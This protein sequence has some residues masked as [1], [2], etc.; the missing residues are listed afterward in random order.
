[1]H[2]EDFSSRND[3][4][5]VD[6]KKRGASGTTVFLSDG[7]SFLLHGS[8]ADAVSLSAQIDELLFSF[9]QSRSEAYAAYAKGFSL[10]A[11][12]EHSVTQLKQKLY[13]RGFSQAAVED[14]AIRLEQARALDD[15]RYA[16]VW[17]RS[18]IRRKRASRAV[19]AAKLAEAG[20]SQRIVA[21]A[22]EE[23]YSSEIELA[24][25]AN[26]FEKLNRKPRMTREKFMA[27]LTRRG[28]SYKSIKKILDEHNIA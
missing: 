27:A 3:N 26:A 17:L 23:L 24:S 28:F 19:L 10:C 4:L 9:L 25:L 13:Q 16:Q 1:M 5:F 15:V 12:R 18:Q 11:R 22:L 21:E 14:A 20:V 7:S 8:D 2:E 6:R